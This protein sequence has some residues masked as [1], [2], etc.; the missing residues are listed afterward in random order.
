MV[1]YL[2]QTDAANKHLYLSALGHSHNLQQQNN[3]LM[4]RH[5]CCDFSGV[6]DV[7]MTHNSLCRH[8]IMQ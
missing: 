6:H 3:K 2:C 7:V 8:I 4:K 5:S 1:T